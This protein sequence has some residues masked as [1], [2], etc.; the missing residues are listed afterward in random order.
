MTNL[1]KTLLAVTCTL[2][3]IA[4]FLSSQNTALE[5]VSEQKIGASKTEAFE[6]LRNFERFPEWSP[7]VVTD[8]DQKNHVTGQTGQIGSVFHWEGV[9]ETSV[10]TQT[11]TAIEEGDYLRMECNIMKPFEG[12]PVFEYQIQETENGVTVIQ[13]FEY[14]CSGFEYAMMSLFG[15][16]THIAETN[17]LGLTRLKD[18]LEKEAG[19]ASAE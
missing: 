5:L 10:G 7:F 14:G 13:N 16:S 19:L 15:V 17:Q 1:F 3:A 12:Q 18:L 9:A 8:P 4:L 2:I 6:L 11:L